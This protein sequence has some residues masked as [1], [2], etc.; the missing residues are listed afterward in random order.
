[1]TTRPLLAE[2]LAVHW[3]EAWDRQQT[4]YLP[5]REEQFDAVAGL[6]AAVAGPR[7]RVLDLGCG[8]GSL[9]RAVHERIPEAHVT[10]ID[11]DPLLLALASVHERAGW[12]TVVDADLQES[13]WMERVSGPFDAAIAAT[14]LHWLPA[15]KLERTY[16]TVRRLLRPGGIFVNSDTMPDPGVTV[17]A[18]AEV[19]RDEGD[20]GDAWRRWWRDAQSEPALAPALALRAARSGGVGS[21]EFMPPAQWHLAALARAGF[22]GARVAWRRGPDAVLTA[23]AA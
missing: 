4:A 14:A 12:L 15:A 10:G 21:A 23:V 5:H 17:P 9:G 2:A 3:I 6:V 16:V 13:S 22:E 18:A 20:E 11:Q 8:P 1:M 7:P 19:V